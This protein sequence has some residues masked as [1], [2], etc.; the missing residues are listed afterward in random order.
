MVGSGKHAQKILKGVNQVNAFFKFEGQNL[1]NKTSFVIIFF[2]ISGGGET[3]TE[4]EELAKFR[5]LKKKT[6]DYRNEYSKAKYDRIALLLPKGERE[7]LK[8]EAKQKSLSMNA[9]LL[10]LI[11]RGRETE[12]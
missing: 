9:Y 11:Q 3:V 8:E 2:K 1:T 6:E 7:S 10:E 12:N 5:A 4:A